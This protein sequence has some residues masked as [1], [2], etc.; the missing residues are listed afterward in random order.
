MRLGR[1]GLPNTR[2][3]VVHASL[4]E[5]PLP[6]VSRLCI[7]YALLKAGLA[8]SPSN[9]VV[10]LSQIWKL[11]LTIWVSINGLKRSKQP[12]ETF[13]FAEVTI[14]VKV[15]YNKPGF[16]HTFRSFLQIIP[17]DDPLSRV[18]IGVDG[19]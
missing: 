7:F 18:G 14:I 19:S 6:W 17:H 1:S 15:S 3:G 12:R 10:C 13:S 5:T 4:L 16:I 8:G 2:R 11:V 9:P